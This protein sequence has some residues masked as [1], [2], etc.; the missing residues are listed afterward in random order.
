MLVKGLIPSDHYREEHGEMVDVFDELWEKQEVKNM[1]SEVTVFGP[2]YGGTGDIRCQLK[3]DGEW[4]WFAIDV[5]TSRAVYDSHVAQLAAYGAADTYAKEVPKGTGGAVE[6]K[7]KWYVA[8]S[9]PPVQRYAVL[10]IRPSDWDDYGNY[11]EPHCT[12]HPIDQEKID[13]G[14]EM[15]RGSV[16]VRKG[17]AAYN[18]IVRREKKEAQ[19]NE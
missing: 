6:Y 11:I 9:L 14:Y 8:E 12:L 13:A 10:Q 4:E 19:K 5:K 16:Q 18:R 17:Q 1:H 7:K 2:D 15:F 3:V